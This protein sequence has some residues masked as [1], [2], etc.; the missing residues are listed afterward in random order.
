LTEREAPCNGCFAVIC[1]LQSLV[2]YFMETFNVIGSQVE[3]INLRE[4]Q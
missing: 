4:C 3:R 1:N 2:V